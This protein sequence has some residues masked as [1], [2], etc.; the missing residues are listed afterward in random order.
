MNDS[1]R[2]RPSKHVRIPINLSLLQSISQ[3]CSSENPDT[4]DAEEIIRQANSIASKLPAN[5]REDLLRPHL[6]SQSSNPASQEQASVNWAGVVIKLHEVLAQAKHYEHLLREISKP[7]SS[8]QTLEPLTTPFS[9]ASSTTVPKSPERG[10]PKR[11]DSLVI[12]KETTSPRTTSQ[13]SLLRDALESPPSLTVTSPSPSTQTPTL[14]TPPPQTP[15]IFASIDYGHVETDP[16]IL[17]DG[18][19]FS[20]SLR[21]TTSNSTSAASSVGNPVSGPNSFAKSSSLQARRSSVPFNGFAAVSTTGP[22]RWGGDDT[23]PSFARYSTSPMPTDWTLPV[24]RK[25]L[26]KLTFFF[27]THYLL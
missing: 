4:K 10:N 9:I 7:T 6:F 15:D 1:P 16:V 14:Q 24:V 25:A 12:K 11:A 5:L 21:T 19:I 18:T 13:T 26:H 3:L 2:E 27:L 22:L 8:S 17:P 23:P 20:Q